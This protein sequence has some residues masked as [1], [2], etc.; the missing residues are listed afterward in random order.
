MEQVAQA[1]A[2]ALE[3]VL[4]LDDAHVGRDLH[5]VAGRDRGRRLL[6]PLERRG[7]DVGDVVGLEVGRDESRHLAAEL[8]EVEAVEA[9]VEHAARGCGPHRGA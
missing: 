7:D 8:G 3:L 9:A 6:G 4:R 2:A 1:D 5:V